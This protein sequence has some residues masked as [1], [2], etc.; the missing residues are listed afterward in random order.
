MKLE[1]SREAHEIL[2]NGGSE[3]AVPQHRSLEA[4]ICRGTTGM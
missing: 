2:G 1:L 4:E 3:P